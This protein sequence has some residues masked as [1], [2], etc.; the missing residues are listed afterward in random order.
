MSAYET[1]RTYVRTKRNERMRADP[2]RYIRRE[3]KTRG[4]ENRLYRAEVK[5]WKVGKRCAFPGCNKRHVD[6]HHKR[7]KLGPLLR[8]QRFWLPLC[9]LH[10]AWIGDHPTRAR[11]LGL[12][13]E[14]GQWN[15]LPK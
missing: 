6:C 14:H 5:F 15:S 12:L 3:S 11:E 7:G 13:C 9:R 8:D 4:R 10:H 2:R 1:L